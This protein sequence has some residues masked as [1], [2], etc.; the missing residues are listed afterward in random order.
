MVTIEEI[1]HISELQKLNHYW[2]ML[3]EYSNSD[4][5]FVT[6]E[7]ISTWLKHFW[8]N[9]PIL[10]LLVKNNN[11]KPIGLAP[12]LI[13]QEKDRLIFPINA[14]SHRPDFVFISNKKETLRIIFGYLKKKFKKFKLYLHEVETH[15]PLVQ[16]LPDILTECN[17]INIFKESHASPFL[18]ITTDW[19]TYFKSKSR[20]FRSEQKRKL[21]KIK[22]AGQVNFV[23]VSKLNQC[24]SAI[25]DILNIERNSWKEKTKTSFTAVPGLK[26][27][28]SDLAYICAQNRWLQIYLLYFNSK[29]IAHIYGI[30]YKNKYYALKTSYHESY[31]KLSPGVVLFNYALQD[32]FESNLKEFDF[33]GVESRW[34][35]ELASDVRKHL[36]I[37]IYPRTPTTV[38]LQFYEH[39][40]K[41]LVREK[42]PFILELRKKIKNAFVERN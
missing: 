41:P 12:F 4:N 5:L 26:D 32:V 38:F 22:K 10:F 40:F 39:K 24:N 31:K 42:A 23:K 20:H 33:L 35:K 37:F 17:L 1:T 2:Q 21:N 25:E 18:R 8:K 14:Y 30:V 34:K 3:I 13:E 27:F 15:S 36:D 19:Q 28:Y 29:P 16:L 9:K 6:Y 11:N 7:W